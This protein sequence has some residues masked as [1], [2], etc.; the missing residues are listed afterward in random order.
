MAA[1]DLPLLF[2]ELAGFEQH[3]VGNAD[4]ANVVQQGAAPYVHQIFV[5]DIHAARD[6]HGHGHDPFAVLLSFLFLERQGPGPAL[7]GSVVGLHQLLVLAP[8]IAEQQ[9]AVHRNG[10]LPTQ[11]IKHGSPLLIAPAGRTVEQFQHAQGAALGDQRHHGVIDKFLVCQHFLA[12]QL[13]VIVGIGQKNDYLFQGCAPGG[14]LAEGNGGALD[15]G[16]NKTL[17]LPHIPA[18]DCEHQRT[19]WLPHPHPAG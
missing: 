3:G 13:V 14:T 18:A 8:Q 5:S 11:G 19:G 17:C 4:F 6:L 10:N 2:V 12:H 16:G 9:G 15:S 7:Q 1:H